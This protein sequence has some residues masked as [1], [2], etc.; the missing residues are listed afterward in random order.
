VVL[1]LDTRF[2][3]QKQEKYILGDGKGNEISHFALL[4][5][6]RRYTPTSKFRRRV[7]RFGEELKKPPQEQQPTAIQAGKIYAD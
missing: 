7:P 4:A 6:L 3:G 1:G 2:L 5:M